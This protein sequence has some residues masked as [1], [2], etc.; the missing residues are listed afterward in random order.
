[1]RLI[2]IIGLLFI[3]VQLFSQK[4]GIIFYN[5]VEGKSIPFI[6]GSM[7]VVEYQG[8]LK[9]MELYTN[10]IIEVNDSTVL[11]GK[12]RLFAAPTQ[13]KEIRIE[14]IKGFRKISAGS[15]LLK[16]TLTVGATLGA[17]YAMRNYADQL[18]S[19]EEILYSTAIGLA[20]NISLNKIFPDKKVKYKMKDGWKVFVR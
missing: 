20:T 4:T 11:I 19:T 5:Q 3:G 14:D 18:S 6:K 15:L 7:I 13:V 12:A 2:I 10:N 1:M 17:Y 16:T 9:Q 8:Y